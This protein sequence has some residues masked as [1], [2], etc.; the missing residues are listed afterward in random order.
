LWNFF[1]NR[2]YREDI[3]VYVDKINTI[4]PEKHISYKLL[5][6]KTYL[7]KKKLSRAY[8]NGLFEITNWVLKN[9]IFCDTW[10][11]MSS[12][13]TCEYSSFKTK[14]LFGKNNK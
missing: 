9:N 2:D 12:V 6:Q 10:N 11:F 1:Y 3:I 8:K 14:A 5:W 7:V 4:T 13:V